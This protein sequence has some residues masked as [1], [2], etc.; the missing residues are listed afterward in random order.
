MTQYRPDK[1]AAEKQGPESRRGRQRVEEPL[2]IRPWAVAKVLA[3]VIGV[4]IV[5]GALANYAIF[6]LAPHPEHDIADV[7]K[8]FD[9]GHE[10]SIPAFY[11]AVVMLA[12]SAVLW[13]LAKYDHQGEKERRTAWHILAF[14]MLGLAIDEVVM[15][16][17]MG[18]AAMEK[19]G[20]SG[21]FY[22]S[23]VI[24]GFI[25]VCVFVAVFARLLL[26]LDLRTRVLFIVSGLLFISGAIGM[27]LIAGVIFDAAEDEAAALR[28][29]SH[30]LVQ[31]VEEGLEMLGMALF[32]CALL[33]YVNLAGLSCWLRR[34]N[35]ASDEVSDVS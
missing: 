14:V 2:L 18:T 21:P 34:D 13:F 22:F 6:N 26:K 5:V 11:S 33:D 7:L 3:G 17:E 23:W 28:S 1:Q 32:L 25:F 27:E 12:S 15:F 31:A 9:L 20:L 16:H 19:F 35:C 30:V 29:V 8:R 24:P 4:L 10:P